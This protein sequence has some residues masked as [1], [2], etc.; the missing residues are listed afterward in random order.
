[1]TRLK[2]PLRP[3]VALAIVA[4]FASAAVAA[5]AQTAS[6][7]APHISGRVIADDTGLPIPGAT[8]QLRHA[9]SGATQETTADASGRYAFT[10]PTPGA[11][12]VSAA[13]RG[14]LTSFANRDATHPFGRHLRVEHSEATQA[15]VRLPRTSAIEGR[16]VD[17]L[18]GPVDDV[19]VVAFR[20]EYAMG[21]DRLNPALTR[22]ESRS[23][24]Q[25]RYRIPELSPGTY[26]VLAVPW[27][28]TPTNTT[29]RR[30]PGF[31]PTFSGDTAGMEDAQPVHVP[32]VQDVDAGPL[33]LQR[34]A[35]ATIRGRVVT[36]DGQPGAGWQ[37]LLFADSEV[38]VPLSSVV[39]AGADGTFV[40]RDL[41]ASSFVVQAQ[42]LGAR[43][44]QF[45]VG[46]GRLTDAETI[47]TLAGVRPRTMK[48]TVDVDGAR[49]LA[50]RPADFDIALEPQD[51]SGSPAMGGA[52]RGRLDARFEATIPNL[53]GR[54]L[55]TVVRTPRDLMLQSVTLR[56]A[57]VTDTGVDVSRV[58][59]TIDV[60]I[61]FTTRTTRLRGT[62][63]AA[64]GGPIENAPLILYP[65]NED[66]WNARRYSAVV[67][68][69]DAGAFSVNGLPPGSYFIACPGLMP[70]T[71]WRR[72]SSWES[73][74]RTAALTTLTAGGES[75]VVV[76][77]H[78]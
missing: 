45:A 75:H 68:T 67:H 39:T 22:Y 50:Y 66:L 48:V 13:A 14:F 32:V 46:K 37:V 17:E 1:M 3:A 5:F 59:G 76:R 2:K 72:R 6:G 77:C 62:L 27:G 30:L 57:D 36:A 41:P 4:L 18:G 28:P 31:L 8:V 58:E 71:D 53:W 44:G 69:D 47:V 60:A 35:A 19:T 42:P 54:Q 34:G 23:D 20:S 61:S 7:Q 55:V 51:L 29:E 40:F 49:P 25:G 24:E 78:Q 74:K 12:L 10:V 11:Y 26:Y 21:R 65:S 63:V 9:Q 73:F 33:R 16:I 38:R 15:I 64:T 56:G 52:P 70:E 43:D